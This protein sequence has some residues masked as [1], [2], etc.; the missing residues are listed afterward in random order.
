MICTLVTVLVA[1]GDLL[2]WMDK[3]LP[4]PTN[5]TP[6]K[7]YGGEYWNDKDSRSAYKITY[8]IDGYFGTGNGKIFLHDMAARIAHTLNGSYEVSKQEITSQYV[9]TLDRFT[10][11]DRVP[12]FRRDLES[13]AW[14]GSRNE[15]FH[16]MRH[17][18]YMMHKSNTLNLEA[19]TLYGNQ[20]SNSSEH[21][22]YLSPNIFKWVEA[23]Y[24][25][26]QST[27]TRQE[28]GRNAS[29][30]KS[31]RIRQKIFSALKSQT[32]FNFSSLNEASKYL[33]VS[34]TTFKKYLLEHEAIFKATQLLKLS[35]TPYVSLV[36]IGI[37][38]MREEVLNVVLWLTKDECICYLDRY[39]MTDPP[40]YDKYT[41]KEKI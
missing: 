27:M 26:K 18:A 33:S 22:K 35:L 15:I 37:E 5:L 38:Q 40:T 20:I 36:L 25:G 13:N 7:M 30:V 8:A 21:V 39:A 29:R 10:H 31:E 2:S 24:E 23:N 19:L 34:W 6:V 4:T 12:S 9:Y 41:V 17:K 14:N 32:L 3:D 28:A 16:A 11:L 1:D